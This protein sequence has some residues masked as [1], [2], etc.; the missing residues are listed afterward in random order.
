MSFQFFNIFT[1]SADNFLDEIKSSAKY[2]ISHSKRTDIDNYS[3]ELFNKYFKYPTLEI[4][5]EQKDHTDLELTKHQADELLRNY[6]FSPSSAYIHAKLFTY[7]FNYSGGLDALQ[8]KSPTY[9]N[10]A[11]LGILTYSSITLYVILQGNSMEE[12]GASAKQRKELFLSAIKDNNEKLIEYLES[13]KTAY[14][15]FIKLT[16]QQ[17]LDDEA[18]HE[19]EKDLY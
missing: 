4:T 13:K 1:K 19:D 11:E 3:K 12:M 5:S 16:I 14:L 10:R 6:Q 7:Q 18:K 8:I 2:E 17:K 9:N 15:N